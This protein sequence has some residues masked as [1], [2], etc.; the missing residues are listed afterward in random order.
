MMRTIRQLR[1]GLALLCGLAA[2][3]VAPGALAAEPVAW[4]GSEQL[5]AELPSSWFPEVT[6][7]QAGTVW[8]VWET[9]RDPDEQNVNDAN[10]GAI[11]LARRDAQGWSAP[12]NIYVKDIYNA[13]RPLLMSD[14]MYL[15]LLFRTVPEGT[16]VQ[17]L[18]RMFHMRAP[19]SGDPLDARSWS[20]PQPLSDTAAY[21]GQ[22]VMTPDGT[23]VTTYNQMTD[24]LVDG[25][26][27]TRMALYSRRSTD[28]GRTWS[29][30]VK[31]S[32]STLRA[33]RNS[34]LALPDGT[35]LAA[36]DEGYDNLA[37]L[38]EPLGSATAISTDG[39]LTW[40][41]HTIFRRH[42]EQVTLATDGMRV[43]MLYRSTIDDGLYYRESLDQGR[44]WSDEL[45]VPDVTLE[46]YPGQHN[47]NRLGVATDSAGTITVAYI[48]AWD[49]NDSG[50]AVFTSSF[51]EA[52][53]DGPVLAAAVEEGFPEYPRLAVALGNQLELVFFVRAERFVESGH[54][55]IW[56]AGGT[57]NAPALD[58]EPLLPA[59]TTPPPAD[60]QPAGEPAP[61]AVWPSLPPAPEPLPAGLDT[62]DGPQAAL[63]RPIVW[64]IAATAGVLLTILAMH[65][66]WRSFQDTRI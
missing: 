15:H 64:V 1:W 58:P 32:Q 14:G 33:G 18:A 53:W 46:A 50:L 43:L 36:W 28:H 12:A 34:L 42:T 52:E 11:M 61:L 66:L 63:D 47:F 10:G 22:L 8:A 48:G 23:L 39:G 30:P 55:T 21:W 35:L 13:G 20:K 3:A 41:G 38:G 29:R 6:A 40:Q 31:I 62:S 54:N 37:G 27:D 57:S 4:D 65:T 9:T 59:P 2:L 51:A 25:E 7:D 19:L 56:A 60:S 24:M 5:G 17:R 26:P 16:P 44:S 49:G 45:T